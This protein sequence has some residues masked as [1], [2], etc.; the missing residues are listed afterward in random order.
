MHAINIYSHCF[1][2]NSY[3]SR[4]LLN[5]A[6]YHGDLGDDETNLSL[7]EAGERGGIVMLPTIIGK[8]GGRL[9]VDGRVWR[10][11]EF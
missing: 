1:S 6:R 5:C 10:I 11:K 3:K 2:R 7:A 4:S 8:R 9:H